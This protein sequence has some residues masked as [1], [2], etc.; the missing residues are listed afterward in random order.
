MYV[1]SP[2]RFWS[3]V[4][5]G[6]LDECWP[7][8]GKST[9]GKGYGKFA[10][11]GKSVRAHR[12]AWKIS[13]G[14]IPKDKIVLHKCDNRRCCNLNHLYLG[15]YSDNMSDRAQRNSDNQGGR[16]SKLTLND[17]RDI[18][19]LSERNVSKYEIASI[20]KVSLQ[21]IYMLISGQRGIN[22]SS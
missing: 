13:N 17:V 19:Q 21:Y 18:R 14:P 4:I 22:L 5:V 16:V 15:T 9:S 12:Y 8:T 11:G 6:G 3:K 20:Y 1:S 2:K 7:Y 10:A